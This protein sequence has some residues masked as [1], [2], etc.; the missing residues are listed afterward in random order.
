MP[1]CLIVYYSLGGTTAQV[2]EHIAA[3]LHSAG[4]EVSLCDLKDGR[5]PDPSEYDLLGIGTP[6][7]YFRPPFNVMDFVEDL[8]P[9]QGQRTF[10]FMLNGTYRY[11]ASQP[12]RRELAR[13]GARQ[14]GFFG[15]YGVEHHVGYLRLGYLIS[16]GHPNEAELLRA[17][18]FGRQL[19]L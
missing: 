12:L 14:I 15:C 11:G 2:A 8:P 7:Y 10:L 4:Y 1:S 9:L 18:E 3:G 13:K 16:A 19:K 5:P 17:E 6:V